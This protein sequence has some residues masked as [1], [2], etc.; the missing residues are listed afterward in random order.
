MTLGV[1]DLESAVE[2]YVKAF[3]AIPLVE[4]IDE[5]LGAKYVVLHLGDCLLQIA[6]PLEPT[7]DLGRHVEQYGNFIY[8]L[9]FK[10]TDV[11]S[12]E[13]WLAKKDVKTSR[14]RPGLLVLEPNDTFNAPIF[15]TAEEIQGDPFAT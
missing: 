6:Q 3:K 9:R 7:S 8:S 11:D 5:D 1:R 2:V 10:I 12:A 4:G 15:L 13:A 14:P